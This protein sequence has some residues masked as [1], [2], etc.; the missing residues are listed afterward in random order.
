[1]VMSTNGNVNEWIGGYRTVAG[2]IQII[3]YNNA[4]NRENPQT[5]DST[6]WKA[7]MPD[8]SLVDPGTA[9]TLKWDYANSKITLATE[10]TLQEDAYKGTGFVS[11]GIADGIVCPE[12]MKALALFPA[13]ANSYGGDYFYMNNGAAER[14]AARG[15][16]WV[17]GSSA[18]VFFLDGAYA[19]S[20][21]HHYIGFRSA[22]VE[23]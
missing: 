19:R 12:V 1:M 10:L 14:L 20:L 17:H 2:E 5:V 18:G 23:L 9:G 22:F 7:I 4:A 16:Y 13:D 11:L 21:T 15:G 8:G 3:P 6:F